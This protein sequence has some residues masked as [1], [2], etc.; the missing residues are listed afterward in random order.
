M[1]S[2]RGVPNIRL[3]E[4]VARPDSSD[5]SVVLID[6]PAATRFDVGQRA[7]EGARVVLVVPEGTPAPKV[8][9]IAEQLVAEEVEGL[10]F[11]RRPPRPLARGL[12]GVSTARLLRLS[13]ANKG[14]PAA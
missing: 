12:F 4:R 1:E 13:T 6:G 14:R 5:P 11:V 2:L 3:F 7:A 10:V 8:T 9:A